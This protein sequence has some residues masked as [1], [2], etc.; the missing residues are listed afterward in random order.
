LNSVVY[1]FL[2]N[3]PSISLLQT[4]ILICTTVQNVTKCGKVALHGHA[5]VGRH[6]LKLSQA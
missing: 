1:S 4:Y 3:S 2:Q 5:R 6:V